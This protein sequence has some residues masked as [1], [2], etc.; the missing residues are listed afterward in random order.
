MLLP[1]REETSSENGKA[2]QKIPISLLRLFEF[3]GIITKV[4]V[5]KERTPSPIMVFAIVN[6]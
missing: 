3:A 5:K 2:R 4:T 1:L 6:V